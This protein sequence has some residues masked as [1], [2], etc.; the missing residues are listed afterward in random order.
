ITKDKINIFTFSGRKVVSKVAKITFSVDAVQKQGFA[1]F[2]LKEIHEQPEILRLMLQTRLKGDSVRLEGLGL[3]DQ[4]LK[5]VKQIVIVACGTAYHAGLV[6][7]YIIE[8]LAGIPVLVDVSSE[9][10]YRDPIIDKKT[11]VIA[12]SQSGETADTL[13]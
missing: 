10:R 13:A 9:F 12:I 4:K 1:H 6:G 3:T 5:A 7:K 8:K 11:L 2:M